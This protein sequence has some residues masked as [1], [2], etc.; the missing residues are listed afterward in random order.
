MRP[1]KTRRRRPTPWLSRAVALAFLTFGLT[2]CGGAASSMSYAPEAPQAEPAP[3][4]ARD[5]AGAAP[6]A[7]VSSYSMKKSFDADEESSLSKPAPVSTP[8]QPQAPASAAAADPLVV[9]SGYLHLRVKRMV[10]TT[11]AVTAAAEKFGGYIESMTET[12]VIVRVPVDKFDAAMAVFEALGTVL[13]REVKALDVTAQFTDVSTRLAVA[14]E[15]RKRLLALLEATQDV[16]Q[17]LQ[18]LQEIKRLSEQIET[19]S[20]TLETLRKLADFSTI[21]LTLEPVVTQQ[22]GLVHRSS[23][24]WVRDLEPY[25]TTLPEGKSDIG[26]HVPNG[27]V[28]FEDDD[29]YRAQAADTSTLR[30][31]TVENEPRGDAAFWGEAIDHEMTG[32]DEEPVLDG[33]TAGLVWRVYRSKDAAPQYMLVGVLSVGDKLHVLEGFFPTEASWN[34]HKEAVLASL[35]TFEAK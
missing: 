9:Y 19:M 3:A 10:E 2:A 30:G 27:F 15:A 5:A 17:R 33:T 22:A 7:S 29:T 14:Q 34:R 18:I 23:F 1:D 28:L 6:G 35:G 20:S 26:Y 32:R 16:Q 25:R 31:G 24:P 11:D 8:T 4:Y 21:T 12:V 13:G